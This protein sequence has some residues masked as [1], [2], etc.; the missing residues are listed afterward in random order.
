[1]CCLVDGGAAIHVDVLAGDDEIGKRT[2]AKA[3]RDKAA[4]QGR[5]LSA[6]HVRI[7]R[8]D[9]VARFKAEATEADV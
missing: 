9:G 8:V 2:V 1:V 5:V 3:I 6:V 4:E 7:S